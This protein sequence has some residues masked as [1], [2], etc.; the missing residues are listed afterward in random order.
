MK[1]FITLIDFFQEKTAA[2]A[3]EEERTNENVT[4]NIHLFIFCVLW[5]WLNDDLKRMKK[6]STSNKTEKRK[7]STAN[8]KIEANKQE[9]MKNKKRSLRQ[10]SKFQFYYWNH[11][12]K[13]APS[14][15]AIFNLW[16]LNYDTFSWYIHLF[17]VYSIPSN[18]DRRS[19]RNE[20]ASLFIKNSLRR[21]SQCRE[22]E[23]K[24]KKK[25]S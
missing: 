12:M 2:A 19:I 3:A 1:H 20:A 13:R 14:F 16:F 22:G 18:L 17:R 10:P 11:E 24:K 7:K 15:L 9:Q 8:K 23:A 4:L 5:L 21:R 6:S 25:F